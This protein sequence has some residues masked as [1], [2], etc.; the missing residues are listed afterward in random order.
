MNQKTLIVAIASISGVLYGPIAL[1]V[2]TYYPMENTVS[3]IDP[4]TIT[5][6]PFID[7]DGD[8]VEDDEDAFPYD[9][10]EWLDSDGDGRGNNADPDDDNDRISDRRERLF[11]LDPLNPNDAATADID[12]DG[13]G[14]HEDTD[15]D[16]DGM[17]D[18]WEVK[19]GLDPWNDNDADQ[20]LD[21]D[22]VTNLAEF[23]SQTNPKLVDS[24]GDGIADNLDTMSGNGLW[25]YACNVFNTPYANSKWGINY[26]DVTGKYPEIGTSV[27]DVSKN[28]TIQSVA[29]DPVGSS[30][31]FS[32]KETQSGDYEI[33]RLDL[34]SKLLTQ[35]TANGTDDADVTQSQDG[36]V[37]AWQVRLDDGRQA[38]E[39]RHMKHNGQF[40]SEILASA[41]PF[42]QPS[43]SPNGKWLTLVQ[44]RENVFTLLRY[45]ILNKEFIIIRSIPRRKKLYHPSVSNDGNIVGW[46]ENMSRNRFRIK[47][48]ALGEF[49]D[50]LNDLNGIEH[51]VVSGD[52][53]RVV[54]SINSDEV[55]KT[56]MTN[57]NT[58]ETVSIGTSIEYPSRYL[59]TN[60]QGTPVNKE[61]SSAIF[62]NRTLVSMVNE[63]AYTFYSNGT[64]KQHLASN[65]IVK[66][67]SWYLDAD[68]NTLYLTDSNTSQQ[69]VITLLNE[70]DNQ[71][72]IS[73]ISDDGSGGVQHSKDVLYQALPLSVNALSDFIISIDTTE[74]PNC[75]NRTVR[76]TGQSAFQRDRCTDGFFAAQGSLAD[77]PSVQDQVLIDGISLN[78]GSTKTAQVVLIKGTLSRGILAVLNEAP[79]DTDQSLFF[80]DVL[81]AGKEVPR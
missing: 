37:L 49:T 18:V 31:L 5:Y 59:A 55:G 20:D 39:L 30:A 16:G 10:N 68:S 11:G 19:Y 6:Y 36:M 67:F 35:L 45:D 14:N 62:S 21:Q 58:L 48:V 26:Y 3:A 71:Y 29:C 78:G 72:T 63:S 50:I 57:I 32:L 8:N 27:F 73:I 52:G 15:D 24:D 70:L 66:E 38:V 47:N 7:T 51:A 54:Y 44:L 9:P 53:E 28:R 12:G 40:T 34:E 23:Q 81:K 76:F 69:T 60:W 74:E 77:S 42:V 17:P 80:I 33:Y 2:P 46:T 41:S 13:L 25:G 65:D 64:G 4:E 22:L 75:T 61:F 1:A 43:L 79:S 56:Y